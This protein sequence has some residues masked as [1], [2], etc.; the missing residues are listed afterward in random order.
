MKN[1]AM[2]AV[3]IAAEITAA[4]KKKHKTAARRFFIMENKGGRECGIS[5][6]H[7]L[8]PLF[9]FLLLLVKT[10]W[11]NT[12]CIIIYT[13]LSHKNYYVRVKEYE[14]YTYSGSEKRSY[15]SRA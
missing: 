14:D 11:Y 6:P 3:I 1:A 13:R 5:A 15:R 2:T 12:L 8:P 10:L 4:V 9:S 7:S